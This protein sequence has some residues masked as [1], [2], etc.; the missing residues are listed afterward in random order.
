M[1]FG[2][3]HICTGLFLMRTAADAC[4]FL[5]LPE[6]KLQARRPDADGFRSVEKRQHLVRRHIFMPSGLVLLR[7]SPSESVSEIVCAGGLADIVFNHT[8][9]GEHA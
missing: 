3:V 5:A 7:F 9:K 2:P 1:I 8:R 4:F 6:K